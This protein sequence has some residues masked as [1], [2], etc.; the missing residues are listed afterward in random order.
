MRVGAWQTPLAHSPAN[1]Y[2]TR[3]HHPA[4]QWEHLPPPSQNTF[5]SNRQQFRELIYKHLNLIE[6]KTLCFDLDIDHEDF[7]NQGKQ[8]VIL[9]LLNHN[10]VSHQQIVDRLRELRSDVDWPDA[11]WSKEIVEY[12][13]M[14]TLNLQGRNKLI[15]CIQF[16]VEGKLQDE[17]Q[18]GS[19]LKLRFE[20]RF[21]SLG[22]LSYKQTITYGEIFSYA[23][24]KLVILGE[25]G[26]GKTTTLLMLVEDLLNQ[27]KA[28]PNKP[29]PLIFELSTW[30][31]YRPVASQKRWWQYWKQGADMISQEPFAYWLE[32]VTQEYGFEANEVL[33]MLKSGEMVLFLD[34]LDE[35]ATEEVETCLQAINESG[36]KNI[37]V[38]CRNKIYQALETNIRGLIEVHILPLVDEDIVCYLADKRFRQLTKLIE[39]DNKL[40]ELVRTPLMLRLMTSAFEKVDESRLVVLQNQTEKKDFL[41]DEYVDQMF[42]RNPVKDT[43]WDEL[44]AR[45]WLACLADMMTQQ[46]LTTFMIERIQPNWIPTH[47]STSDYRWRVGLMIGVLLTLISLLTGNSLLTQLT[48]GFLGLT[49]GILGSY[50]A[51]DDIQ[52]VTK[53]TLTIPSCKKILSEMKYNVPI[54]FLLTFILCL[55]AVAN[56]LLSVE[57][58]WKQSMI[59]L[60]PSIPLLY[61]GAICLQMMFQKQ[62]IKVVGRPNRTIYLTMLYMFIPYGLLT[63]FAMGI[64]FFVGF[65]LFLGPVDALRGALGIG[66]GTGLLIGL[67]S[68]IKHFLL[69]WVIS[70][71]NLLPYPMPWQDKQLTAFLG[72]MED[73]QLLQQAEGSW[74]FVHKSLQ[75]HFAAKSPIVWEA[76]R[77]Q[78]RRNRPEA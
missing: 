76:D 24:R 35:V 74:R 10:R 38:S 9:D 49:L 30:N 7:A 37:V 14:S 39:Q 63:G 23:W 29:I 77:M 44:Q 25:P 28:D 16:M 40:K 45:H 65:T 58:P 20:S 53:V 70:N 71:S 32:K 52:I 27:A 5:M 61:L 17:L 34:A 42:N 69:R 59:W 21:N 66:I 54:A 57:S 1:F 46:E 6:I 4:M 13:G 75:E 8:S 60:I 33:A 41:F 68:G 78:L 67:I 64:I 56:D 19:K 48:G 51:L 26:S 72:S 43:D 36:A 11:T 47:K 12:S 18:A 2:N 73:R 31:I 55:G 62:A 50:G 3:Q 22:K 15:N